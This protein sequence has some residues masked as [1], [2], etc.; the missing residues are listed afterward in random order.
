MASAPSLERVLPR[1][2][3]RSLAL[4]FPL[5]WSVKRP[6]RLP[7]NGLGQYYIEWQPGGGTYGEDWTD[8]PQDADGVLLT[9]GVAQ[10][11]PVRIAQFGLHSHARFLETGDVRARADFMAQARWLASNQ[12][13]RDGVAGCYVYGFPNPHYGAGPGWISAMAQGEAISLL[14][15]AAAA[16]RSDAYVEAAL[17]AA[18][19]FQCAIA[20]GGV[21]FRSP[22]G[23]AFLE[24]VAVLPAS[25]ILNGHIFALWGLLELQ[26]LHAATWLNELVS[27]ATATLRARLPLY[28]AGYWSYYSLLGA[29]GGFRH[30]AVLKYHAFHI[31]QLRVTAAL[32]NDSSFAQTADRWQGYADSAVCRARVLANTMAGLVPRFLTRS[33]SVGHGAVDVLRA[34]RL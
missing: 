31:A 22:H 3:L 13:E 28:D 2:Y 14:L 9:R 4:A 25:H 23:D 33:D 7:A 17:R 12:V 10:Y 16:E 30:A 27:A 6:Y 11:H 19:P 8:A 24:E 15:R 26:S 20:H 29:P 34:A 32:V 5:D 18:A 1:N 21:V